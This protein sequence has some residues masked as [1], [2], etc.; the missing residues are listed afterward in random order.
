MSNRTSRDGLLLSAY[1]LSK[2]AVWSGVNVVLSR[3]DGLVFW[4]SASMT[5]LGSG[6]HAGSERVRRRALAC[7][8]VVRVDI[9]RCSVPPAVAGVGVGGSEC[10]VSTGACACAAVDTAVGPPSLGL[11]RF[12]RDGDG[13][14]EGE[15][16]GQAKFG[17]C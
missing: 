16:V 12:M 9:A 5:P 10:S 4:P 14:G 6:L 7:R 1:F 3:F 17:K 11:V 15:D 13:E 2:R 8:L